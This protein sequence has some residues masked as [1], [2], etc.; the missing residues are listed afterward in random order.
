M[1]GI[2]EM[3]KYQDFPSKNLSLTVPKNFTGES[4]TASLV[5]GIKK[6]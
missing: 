5:S 6:C 2:K 3:G 1:L 4:F